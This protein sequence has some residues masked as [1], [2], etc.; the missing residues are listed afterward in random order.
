MPWLAQREQSCC[1]M[2]RGTH[3]RLV[4]G[5][6][7]LSAKGCEVEWAKEGSRWVQKGNKVRP[8]DVLVGWGK[9]GGVKKD[10]VAKE[11]GASGGVNGV[12]MPLAP[13]TGTSVAGG[14]VARVMAIEI[15]GEGATGATVRGS[16][17]KKAGIDI[18][19]HEVPARAEGAFRKVLDEEHA[20]STGKDSVEQ[21]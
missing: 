2:A 3:W 8:G 16:R 21:V 4:R 14:A 11:S 13:P 15:D 12:A 10:L 1:Q 20:V 18:N 7:T 6:V 19:G 9:M 5:E 17:V